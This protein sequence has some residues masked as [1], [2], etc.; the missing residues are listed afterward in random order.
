MKRSL[1]AA[2]PSLDAL[3]VFE[4]A[5]ACLSFTRAGDNLGLTQSAVSRQ[6]IDLE[7]LLQV[8]L[9]SRDKRRL[10]LTPA[11]A[12]FRELI[13]PSIQGLQ[14]AVLAMRMRSARS[15]VVNVSVAA[16][17]CNLWFIPNL[18]GFY[19]EAPGVR[20]NIVPHIGA[21]TFRANGNDAA[22][23]NADAPPPFCNSFKLLDIGVM[24]YASHALLKKLGVKTL[25]DF[26]TIPALQLRERGGIW[27]QY[28]AHVGVTKPLDYLGSNQLLLLNYEAAVAGL[29]AVLLPPE[30]LVPGEAQSGLVPLHE[31]LM[32][33]S[34]SYY[35]CWPEN[36][37]KRD[38]VQA[39]GAWLQREILL[40]RERRSRLPLPA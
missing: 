13:R 15:N 6:I 31:T 5:A 27:P 34:R 20:V 29:G 4:Q 26:D 37:A 32:V 12:E 10:E 9:F 28:L 8:E 17:F 40:S 39:L 18:P 23:V 1:H 38:A 36:G 11:G 35:F 33:T 7:A 14:D 19:A 22:V 25:A 30:F 2:L 3:I 24:P 21:V 16:S